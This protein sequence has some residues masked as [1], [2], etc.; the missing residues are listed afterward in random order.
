ML[1]S[2]QTGT[3]IIGFTDVSTFHIKPLFCCLCAI[4][5]KFLLDMQMQSPLKQQCN[6]KNVTINKIQETCNF[7]YS[8]QYVHVWGFCNRSPFRGKASMTVAQSSQNQSSPAYQISPKTSVDHHSSCATVA[9]RHAS[10]LQTAFTQVWGQT[11]EK[12]Q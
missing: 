3:A 12:R 2:S 8:L 7:I 1:K 5:Y 11:Q 6:W 9:G 4:K 10:F